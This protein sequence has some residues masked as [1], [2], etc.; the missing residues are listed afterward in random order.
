MVSRILS[1]LFVMVAL[2][3]FLCAAYLYLWPPIEE[4]GLVVEEPDRVCSDLVPGRVEEIEFRVHNRTGQTL[5]VIGA[6]GGGGDNDCL[7]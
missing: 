7:T 6:G 4:P 1:L 5:R 2:A 3:A